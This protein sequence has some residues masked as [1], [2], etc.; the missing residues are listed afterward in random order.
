M[1]NLFK[2][3]FDSESITLINFLICMGVSLFLGIIYYL[4]F[5]IKERSSKSF[6][7]SIILLPVI[8]SVVIIMVNGNLGVG[9]AIA[10]AFSLVRFRSAQCSA[11]ELSVIFMTMCTGL[12]IGVGYIGYGIV[13]TLISSLFLIFTNL[14]FTK[15]EQKN[16]NRVLK[17]T[18]PEDLDYEEIFENCLKEY[19]SYY[20]LINVKTTNMGSLFRLTYDIKL[21]KLVK[22]KEFIDRLR[23]EN[24]NL[25]ININKTMDNTNL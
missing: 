3:I 1:E 21:K 25:E 9:V 13:F 22:E 14:I 18:V 20:E 19:T 6:K 7:M 12:I 5:S 4:A 2:N 10:G 23:I 11:K 8:I 16:L 15:V 24:G 17:I